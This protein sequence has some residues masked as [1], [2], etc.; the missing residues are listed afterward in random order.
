MRIGVLVFAFVSALLAA[1]VAGRRPDPDPAGLAGRT[2]RWRWVRDGVHAPRANGIGKA[3]RHAVAGLAGPARLPDAA[4]RRTDAADGRLLSRAAVAGAGS[5]KPTIARRPARLRRGRT[6]ISARVRRGAARCSAACIRAAPM[7]RRAARPTSR[8][9]TRC[10]IRGRRRPA[11][12]M[13][14]ATAPPCWPASAATSARCCAN[15]RRSFA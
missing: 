6:T 13:P 7:S 3:C 4:R 14:T 9:P 2:R 12:W 10:S 8:R 1:I 11:R 5:R 15:M